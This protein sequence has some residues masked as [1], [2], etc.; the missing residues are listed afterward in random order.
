MEPTSMR[1]IRARYN[2]YLQTKNRVDQ[3]KRLGHSCDKV[4][5]II[6]G[7][8]FMSLPRDYRD[9]FVRNLH[10]ALSGHVSNSVEE[11]V[12]Y[13]EQSDS[14]CIGITIETRPD[15]CLTAADMQVLTSKG[16]M[17]HEELRAAWLDGRFARGALTV[18][19]YDE[20]RAQLVYERPEQFIDN[21]PDPNTPIIDFTEARERRFWAGDD[22]PVR[23]DRHERASSAHLSLRVTGNHDMYVRLGQARRRDKNNAID[24]AEKAIKVKAEELLANDD[25]GAWQYVC[26]M[27][28]GAA[29][30]RCLP[31]AG[32]LGLA[33]PEQLRCFL[34]VFG[35]WLGDGTFESASSGGR[36]RVI[37][38]G[39]KD[40]NAWLVASL[41]SLGLNGQTVVAGGSLPAAVDFK[42]SKA[43]GLAVCAHSWT[44]FFGEEFGAKY[45]NDGERARRARKARVEERRLPPAFGTES[46]KWLPYWC[47][48]LCRDEADAVLRGL[49]RASKAAAAAAAVDGAI[50]TS[51]ERF[52]D[53]IVQLAMHAGYSA[54]FARSD[55]LGDMS[56]TAAQ[57]HAWSVKYACNPPTV[58][59][60]DDAKVVD[61]YAGRTYCFTMPSGFLVA[62]R[63]RRDAKG[64]VVQASRPAVVGNCLKSHLGAMLEY[65]C[66]RLEIGVQSPYEDVA[67]DTNRGHTVR[68]VVESFH[69]SKDAG[70]KV[71]MHSMPNLPRVPLDRDMAG[72]R[73]YFENPAF[74]PDGLKIYPTLVIRGTGLYE[75]WKTGAYQ[76]YHPD[77]LVDFL[78]RSLALVPPWTRIYRIQRDIPMPL[79]SSGVEYGNLRQRVLA[80]MRDFGLR[81]RDIRHREV[82]V[83]EVKYKIRP[84]QVELVRRDYYANGGWETF[85]AYEDPRQDLL[86]GMLRLR[87]LSPLSFRP[88][89]KPMPTSMIRELHVYGLAVPIHTRDPTRFQHQGFGTLLIEEAERIA[90]DEHRSAKLA[91][92]SGVGTRHYYRKFGFELDGPYMSKMID[93]EQQHNDGNPFWFFR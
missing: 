59:A 42:F 5:F 30:N 54:T 90:R 43:T 50:F 3:L 45:A 22:A 65:G 47:S 92:I 71:V 57:Q 64:H 18:A 66:T 51:C 21:D 49:R 34:E 55:R 81:C 48:W 17:S 87:R 70:F 28:N 27:P 84:D 38:G 77:T 75:L 29:T 4:E 78:A 13:S 85:L 25:V 91:V 40:D 76:N 14:R 39:R 69:L 31:F 79:V 61:G 82:G 63:A 32:Q 80:R 7:G 41:R 89:F 62:R 16:F 35:F 58:F 9:Y 83:N 86:I 72:F 20:R 52:R 12:R 93:V 60:R 44:S 15:F 1:A 68:A 56:G 73:E 8:T 19:G 2:P 36:A 37:F 23:G 53:E 33:S 11:A 88:E 10:D 26:Q 67:R 6:M 24:F 74:R 46:A